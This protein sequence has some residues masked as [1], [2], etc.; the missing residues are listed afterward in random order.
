[1][2]QKNK[3][4][5]I[6]WSVPISLEMNNHSLGFGLFASRKNKTKKTKKKK[7]RIAILKKMR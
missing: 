7:K 1:M 6:K 5:T 3:I 4:F 2:V